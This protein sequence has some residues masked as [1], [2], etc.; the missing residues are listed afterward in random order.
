MDTAVKASNLKN[1]AYFYGFVC[2]LKEK[3]GNVSITTVSVLGQI[4]DHPPPELKP[5]PLPSELSRS[6]VYR[7]SIEIY[8]KHEECRLLR[9]YAVCLL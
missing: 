2:K 3:N 5:Q 6:L 9:C 1:Y 4:P 7:T 8:I